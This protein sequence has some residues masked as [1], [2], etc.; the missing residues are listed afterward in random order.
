M[1][2]RQRASRFVTFMKSIGRGEF[3]LSLPEARSRLRKSSNAFDRPPSSQVPAMDEAAKRGLVAA[4]ALALHNRTGR[5]V[6]DLRDAIRGVAAQRQAGTN[7]FQEAV[8][9]AM[10]DVANRIQRGTL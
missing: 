2:T 7:S 10:R 1:D 5:P 8:N 3:T 6:A 4:A 9:L